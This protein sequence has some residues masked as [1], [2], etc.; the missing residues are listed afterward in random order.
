MANRR[1]IHAIRVLRYLTAVVL[2]LVAACLVGYGRHRY[3]YHDEFVFELSPHQAFSEQDR[4]PI[5]S[6]SQW[7]RRA[8][9]QSAF[10]Q[11]KGNFLF[12]NGWLCSQ[13]PHCLVSFPI[14]LSQLRHEIGLGL[15]PS[16]VVTK[17]GYNT[18]KW[19]PNQDRAMLAQSLAT[20]VAPTMMFA[21]LFDGHGEN[22]HLSAERA[23]IDVSLPLL[24]QQD[25]IP[26]SHEALLHQQFLLA[27]KGLLQHI[28]KGGSTAVVAWQITSDRLVL[29]SAGDSTALLVRFN[30]NNTGSAN[31]I[32]QAVQH[33]V[34]DPGEYQRIVAAGGNIWMPPGPAAAD[35]SSGMVEYPGPNGGSRFLA[36]SRSLG[37]IEGKRPGYL[38]AEPS[39][40]VVDSLS[41]HLNNPG[42]FLFVI[43]AS[44]G[45][46]DVIPM[47]VVTTV[48]G[49][50]IACHP[51]QPKA[52]G[53][54]IQRLM[55][56]ASAAWENDR[57]GE[58]RDDMTL[59]V[60]RLKVG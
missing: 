49:R 22:G 17:K 47:D 44:D 29:A 58:Y 6:P 42:D 30:A 19:R 53:V 5:W 60:T 27:D 45:I 20:D 57:H 34:T 15:Q 56:Q 40:V 41:N 28:A 39:L 13:P 59:L 9:T 24:L 38:I 52:L 48:L 32:A 7:L 16:C 46:M 51:E 55:D 37:D 33:R 36:M 2:G 31:I 21:A 43:V 50:S 35:N 11:W 14:R 25:T 10:K 54:A 23:L 12:R 8:S 26:F 1:S 18:D 4:L 3:P